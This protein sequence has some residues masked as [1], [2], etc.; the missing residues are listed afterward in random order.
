M[1]NEKPFPIKEYAL[2]HT[3]LLAGESVATKKG[4]MSHARITKTLK[5]YIMETITTAF[6]LHTDAIGMRPYSKMVPPFRV[7]H[8]SQSLFEVLSR[9]EGDSAPKFLSNFL[10]EAVGSLCW[11]KRL[12][13]DVLKISAAA[14]LAF[15]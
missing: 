15:Q 3:T 5:R 11:K 2:H 9:E 13:A 7:F 1:D 6:I 4:K 14:K 10:E 8:S 12:Q